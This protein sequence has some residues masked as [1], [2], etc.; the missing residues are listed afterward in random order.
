MQEAQKYFRQH[1]GSSG[2]K[3]QLAVMAICVPGFS[4][5]TKCILG[6]GAEIKAGWLDPGFRCCQMCL[7]KE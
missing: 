5:L 1:H 7:K 4:A 2:K 3:V 6:V